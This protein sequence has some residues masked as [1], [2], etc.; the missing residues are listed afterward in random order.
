MVDRGFACC[1]NRQRFGTSRIAGILMGFHYPR[2]N[3]QIGLYR[4]PVRDNGYAGACFPQID[5]FS[6]I[7]RI[8]IDHPVPGDDFTAQFCDLFI[9][10]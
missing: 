5:Q 6:G 7:L 9:F 8:V 3:H 4:S 10:G 1:S 2:C